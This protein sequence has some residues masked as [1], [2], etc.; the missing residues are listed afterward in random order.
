MS[1]G[2]Q[3]LNIDENT[4]EGRAR[5]AFANTGWT[6]IGGDAD[7]VR[8]HKGQFASYI[9]CNAIGNGQVVVNIFVAFDGSD[10]TG[11]LAGGERDRLQRQMEH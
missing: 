7:W 4:C 6:D 3:F 10:P 5:V 2:E 9:T 11:N 8:G 1:R